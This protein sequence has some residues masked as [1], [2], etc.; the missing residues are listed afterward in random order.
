MAAAAV[1]AELAASGDLSVADCQGF[2]RTLVL[3]AIAVLFAATFFSPAIIL[4]AL[5]LCALVLL[6]VCSFAS[7]LERVLRD[8]ALS[9]FPLLY[10]GLTLATLPLLWVRPDRSLA[11][12]FPFLRC[13]DR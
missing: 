8:S 13:V 11:A 10:I 6:L 5:G 9:I 7:P 1:V 2:R 12:D 3:I 4:P